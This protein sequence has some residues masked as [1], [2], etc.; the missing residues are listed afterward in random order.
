LGGYGVFNLFSNQRSPGQEGLAEDQDAE[1]SMARYEPMGRLQC[2]DDLQFLK[3]QPGYTAKIGREFSRERRRIFRLYLQELAQDFHRL[4]ARARAVVAS[5]P[6]E[7]S[8]LVGML[9]RQQLRFRYEMAAIEMRLSFSWTGLGSVNAS[10]LIDALATMQAEVSRL[11][12]PSV[13]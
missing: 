2:E 12:A 13:A 5:L 3:A 6:A 4:H 9:I 7:N 11:G 8:P 10:E 1:F